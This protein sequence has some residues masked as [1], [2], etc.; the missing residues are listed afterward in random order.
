VIT[1]RRITAAEIEPLADFAIQGMALDHHAGLRLS[2]PK[3]V[4][5]I[6]HFVNSNSDFQ[7]AAFD[8]NRI[9][10]GIAA[11]VAEM[12]FFERA[13]AHVVMCQARGVPGVGRELL[14][15]LMAWADHDMRVR[16]VQFPEE[17]GA[18][19]G[20]A[21]LLRRYGFNRVQRVCIFRK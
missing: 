7:L 10:G 5:V 2:R 14:S 18:R 1:Y 19:P 6:S 11:C 4:S 20:F 17:F 9:V 21:R 13:E 15:S 16:Q 8:G 12:M 3:V